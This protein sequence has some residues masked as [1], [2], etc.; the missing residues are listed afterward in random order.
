MNSSRFSLLCALCLLLA[1]SCLLLINAICDHAYELVSLADLRNDPALHDGKCIQVEGVY[2]ASSDESLLYSDED[3]YNSKDSDWSVFVMST[4]D[5]LGTN[6][7]CFPQTGKFAV[8]RGVF[9][10]Y[11][12]DELK[13]YIGNLVEVRAFYIKKPQVNQNE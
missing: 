4:S 8:A 3:S 12:S 11:R 2:Y 10:A 13:L 5:N 6:V 1:I 7:A 9:R